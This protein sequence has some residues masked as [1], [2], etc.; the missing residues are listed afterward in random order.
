MIYYRILGISETATQEQVYK[1]YREK[2]K[3]LRAAKRW[4]GREAGDRYRK[5][6]QAYSVLSAPQLRKEYEN[7]L[8]QNRTN[9]QREEVF[10][11]LF[12]FALKTRWKGKAR[13]IIKES[14]KAFQEVERDELADAII[15]AAERYIIE[16]ELE[17]FPV[18][19]NKSTRLFNRPRPWR[20][21]F[22]K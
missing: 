8:R 1:S 5:I 6:V 19:E 7:F 13:E 15:L 4:G 9:I 3:K 2:V 11:S 22:M 20:R 14:L 16:M 10:N 21:L 18:S 17:P 12:Q